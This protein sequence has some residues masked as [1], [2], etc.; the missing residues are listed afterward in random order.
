MDVSGM[1]L[2]WDSN[3]QTFGCGS[4]VGSFPAAFFQ[5]NPGA[6]SDGTCKN[7]TI[8]LAQASLGDLTAVG[9]TPALPS[10]LMPPAAI[11]SASG[12]MQVI[13][14]NHSGASQTVGLSTWKV[15]VL[16]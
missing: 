5:W 14:C 12:I 8:Y 11:V 16:K 10:N 2:N 6:I 13:I 7:N 9:V 15:A 3:A 1:H 4:S